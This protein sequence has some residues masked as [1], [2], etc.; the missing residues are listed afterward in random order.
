[1]PIRSRDVPGASLADLLN[2]ETL[3]LHVAAD[4]W[5]DVVDAAGALL[6][7]TGTIEPEYVAAMKQLIEQHGPYVVIMPEVALLHAHPGRGVHRMGM[8][9]VTLGKPIPFGH[10]RNDPVSIAVAIATVDDHGHWRALKQLVDMLA[11]QDNLRQIKNATTKGE[12]LR[13][14]SAFPRAERQ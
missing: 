2:G 13:M 7:A 4:T 9:M 6:L 1:L 5:T 14:I 12:V 8:S 3:A 10:V 11:N